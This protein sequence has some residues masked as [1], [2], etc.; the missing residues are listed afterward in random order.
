MFNRDTVPQRSTNQGGTV[1]KGQ[2]FRRV[3]CTYH[4]YGGVD[5]M[6]KVFWQHVRPNLQAQQLNET[7]FSQT[8][9]MSC[10]SLL[11]IQ[12]NK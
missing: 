7:V 9:P 2:S 4:P 3:V 10:L 6:L 12:A 5:E 11:V 1:G 8:Q